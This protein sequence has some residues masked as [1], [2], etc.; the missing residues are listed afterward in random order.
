MAATNHSMTLT[1][2]DQDT[3]NDFLKNVKNNHRFAGDTSDESLS[4]EE[5]E[6]SS[7][8]DSDLEDWSVVKRRTP[9]PPPPLPPVPK[10]DGR[11]HTQCELTVQECAIN[12]LECNRC[13]KIFPDAKT[14]KW[15]RTHVRCKF[16]PSINSKEFVPLR[17]KERT[18]LLDSVLN[19]LTLRGCLK[20]WRTNKI[21][22]ERDV[23]AS[24]CTGGGFE[25]IT[26]T[27]GTK[28]FQLRSCP[29][30]VIITYRDGLCSDSE[31]YPVVYVVDGGF[32]SSLKEMF[33]EEHGEEKGWDEYHKARDEHYDKFCAESDQKKLLEDYKVIHKLHHVIGYWPYCVWE[34]EITDRGWGENLLVQV[35]TRS[36][37]F[38]YYTCGG[39]G[40]YVD[41]FH[42]TEPI[43]NACTTACSGG[44]CGAIFAHSRNYVYSCSGG[45]P[46]HLQIL[47]NPNVEENFRLRIPNPSSL[48]LMDFYLSLHDVGTRALG[49]WSVEVE[50]YEE[51]REMSTKSEL[52]LHIAPE[53]VNLV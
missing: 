9:P 36:P 18:E 37:T 30:K 31:E 38:A 17:V 45:F 51:G 5:C 50:L 14:L 6:I 44:D 4:E 11:C 25:R 26:P 41:S 12:P 20:N 3:I 49:G 1:Q 52:L 8:E 46:G 23:K 48:E 15:H 39:G 13:R 21:I 19:R 42:T 43:M 24:L 33:I 28:V 16:T 2:E 53:I 27:K 32:D 40:P 10:A 22:Q 7:D 29:G 35:K 34:G 47:R